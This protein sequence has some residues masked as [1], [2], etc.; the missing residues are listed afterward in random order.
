MFF[1]IM[2]VIDAREYI[3]ANLEQ[4]NARIW[5]ECGGNHREALFS[6]SDFRTDSGAR[7]K[8]SFSRI[9]SQNHLKHITV[10]G[11]VIISFIG[12]SICFHC[13]LKS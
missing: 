11:F 12:S 10:L 8:I 5:P 3:F 4:E 13:S 7:I 6:S 1:E 2:L 9:S